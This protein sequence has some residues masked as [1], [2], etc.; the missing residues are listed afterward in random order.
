[1]DLLSLGKDPIDPDQPTGS[2]VRYEPEFEELQAE[3][4]KLS[5][6][7]SSSGIEW[8]KVNTLS[9]LILAEKSKDLLV[10]SYMA[11]SQV[12]TH[13][14]DGLAVGLTVMHDM[15]EAYWDNLFPPKKRMRGR[16][17]AIEWWIEKTETALE[18]I[19]PE[20]IAPE[21]LTELKE[22]LS[23]IDAMFSEH[24]S[25]PPMLMP[26]Q[27]HIE[28]IPSLTE[29]EPEPPPAVEEPPKAE[30][31]PAE[32]RPAAEPVTRP[33]PQPEPEAPKPAVSPAEPQD[34]A[35]EQDAQKTVNSGMQQIRQA[36]AFI[37][38]NNPMNPAAYRYR[39]IA[40][41]V[42]VTALPPA[43]SGKTQIPVPAPH[44]IQAM[45]DLRESGNW[46]ALLMSAEQKVS[47]FI[48]WVDLNRFVAEALLSLGEGYQN[49]LEAVC[50]ETAFFM[51]RM[52]GLDDLAFS[53][54]TPFADPETKQWLKTIELGAGSV[55]FDQ[56]QI[57][58]AVQ[59]E[60][61]ENRMS[62]II[63]KAQG[64]AK[65][66]KIVEAV[67]LIQQELQNCFSQKE[68]LLWRLVLCQILLG[69]KNKD[70]T[71]PHLEQILNDIDTY[72]LETWDPELALKG[73]KVVW[74]GFSSFSNKVS[75]SNA[76]ETMNR[77]AKL[78]PAEA[79]QLNK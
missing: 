48:F 1:M 45:N 13:Q 33:E 15:V 68:S 76:T 28:R 49:A 60:G 78:D 65:K 72:Q 61:H 17:G 44:D 42:K 35:T 7:S 23:R 63:E 54:G 8:K 19:E 11:V 62:G 27:R 30:L 2:D 34:I 25:E 58:Q 53:D 66:N 52:P 38:E 43:T 14:I 75:K 39:R 20:P 16:L 4:D 67:T 6:P 9:A 41:W 22:T 57:A 36:A 56:I 37:L 5:S 73:L 69:S 70:M 46:N 3:I 51:H 21:K 79:L 26:I 55:G 29:A 71:L 40:A 10:A 24:L 74:A 18:S 64:L 31:P 59:G 32:E 50:Q 47:Q 12:H 77:I